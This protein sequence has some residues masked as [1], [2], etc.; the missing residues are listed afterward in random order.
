M[1]SPV[2][3]LIAILLKL[4]SPGPVL[5]R[6]VRIGKAGQ[7][8]KIIKF[9]TMRNY[10]DK[11]GPRITVAG[12]SR[13]TSMGRILRALKLDELPQLWNVMKGDMSL[14]GP[15]PEVPFYVQFYTEEQKKILAVR[16]GITDASSLIY[17][18]E[19]A[20]LAWQSN[21]ESYYQEMVLPQKLSL[22]MEYIQNISL[23]YDFLLLAKTLFCLFNR[24]CISTE[25]HKPASL[26][27]FGQDGILPSAN[28]LSLIYPEK[29][30]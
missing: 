3:A 16:P 25:Y 19:E 23:K 4:T 13:I 28:C 29:D 18:Y 14:V 15:R 17:R 21:P 30:Q 11:C 22:N 10:A 8:F 20:L 2:F 24:T 6:Q 26:A 1:L 12:D 9:R 27:G 5:Y 7:N